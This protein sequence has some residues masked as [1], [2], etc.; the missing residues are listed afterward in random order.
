MTLMKFCCSSTKI[1]SCGYF[2]STCVIICAT[3]VVWTLQMFADAGWSWGQFDDCDDAHI[4]LIR[5]DMKYCTSRYIMWV[6][7]WLE[8]INHSQ[9]IGVLMVPIFIY[10][11]I[12]IYYIYVKTYYMMLYDIYIYIYSFMCIYNTYFLDFWILFASLD[13]V[14]RSGK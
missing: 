6:N 1:A 13:S 12:Q 8:K 9:C 7:E 3:W 2:S 4:S 14:K 10:I 11:N 5:N